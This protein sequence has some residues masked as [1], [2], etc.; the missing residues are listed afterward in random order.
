MRVRGLH[1]QG[2]PVSAVSGVARV[3]VNL[4]MGNRM[5][6]GRGTAL[7]SPKAWLS[8]TLV[9][10]AT[11]RP[12]C[13]GELTLHIGT[14][15]VPAQVRPLGEHSARLRLSKELPLRI[16]DRALLRDP[17]Q[18]EIV[19]GVQVLD[20]RPPAF[21]RRGAAR[22]RA[23]ELAVGIPDAALLLRRHGL[24]R[25]TELMAMG[26]PPGPDLTPVAGDWVAD[27]G[28]WARL[29]NRLTVEVA[30]HA[31]ANPLDAG[32]PLEAARRALNLPDRNLVEAL[33]R[34]PLTVSGGRIS[35]TG[36]LPPPIRAAVDRLLTHCADRPFRAPDTQWLAEH[37]IDHKVIAAAARQNALLDLGDGVV[38]P[39]DATAQAAVA[40]AVL[41]Q[42]FTASEARRALDTTRRVVIP[43]LERLD[44]DGVTRR[45]DNGRRVVEGAT[46][47]ITT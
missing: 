16:G 13:G 14:A 11:E 45:V 15:A 23:V 8:T 2:A 32:V 3:G 28:Y 18:H 17:G 7:L 41:P 31:R 10:V 20:V 35:T 43:L 6:L 1:V 46:Q 40:L 19:T 39:R 29:S 12:A 30:E 22:L 4:R 33:I 5:R 37:G 47:T 42:P 21:Q 44:A 9:D 38:L 34:P 27:P 26:C 25:H 36:E 24:L